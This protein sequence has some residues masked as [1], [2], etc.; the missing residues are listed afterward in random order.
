[1]LYYR[2]I[3]FVF[4]AL[5]LLSSSTSDVSHETIVGHAEQLIHQRLG[6]LKR[7]ALLKQRTNPCNIDKIIKITEIPFGNSGNNLVEFTHGLWVARELNAT[8]LVP[9]WM[10]HI[11]RPFDTTLINRLFCFVEVVPGGESKKEIIEI[12]S[13]DSFF[14]FKIFQQH[15]EFQ[16]RFGD[17]GLPALSTSVLHSI[18]EHFLVVYSALWSSPREHLLSGGLWIIKNRL[19]NNLRYASA[20]KRSLEGHCTPMMNKCTNT[21]EYSSLELPMGSPLWDPASLRRSHPLCDMPATF[22]HDVLD[23]HNRND[24]RLF[25]AYD[26]QG[27]LGSYA[28]WRPPV[29]SIGLPASL[30]ITAGDLKFLDLFISMHG[31]FFVANP[32]STFSWEIFVVRV[33]LGLESVPIIVTNDI[34]MMH[35]EGFNHYKR[36]VSDR[37][38]SW[39]S[40]IEAVLTLVE[41]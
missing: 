2:Y 24:S 40:I 14:L 36:N 20:H 27:G 6:Q 18:S 22:V 37:W 30:Q 31:D 19:D 32:L 7:L 3:F 28:S 21:S 8:L 25:L 16:E 33:C 10:V 13:E 1:M 41:R 12:T 11:L 9:P 23:M 4:L 34:Y 38:V 29:L 15:G 35:M 39:T 5:S 17:K 26:G